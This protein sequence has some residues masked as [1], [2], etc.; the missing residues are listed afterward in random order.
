[1]PMPASDLNAWLDYF[2][3]LQEIA[4]EVGLEHV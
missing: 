1:M 2:K 3:L 4:D